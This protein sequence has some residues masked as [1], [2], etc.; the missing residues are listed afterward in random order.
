MDVVFGTSSKSKQTVIYRNF[1][2]VKER[3]IIVAELRHGIA[4]SFRVCN[5]NRACLSQE[6]ALNSVFIFFLSDVI[7]SQRDI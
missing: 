2:Y 1:H 5:A 3:D 7:L 4:R 6:I